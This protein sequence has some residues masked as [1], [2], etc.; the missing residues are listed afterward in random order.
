VRADI[1]YECRHIP[2]AVNPCDPLE[3]PDARQGETS[4][5]LKRARRRLA[6]IEAAEVEAPDARR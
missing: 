6:E 3:V 2:A 4:P 5:Y 1:V